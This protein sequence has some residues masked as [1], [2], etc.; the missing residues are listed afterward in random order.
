MGYLKS[1]QHI[2]ITLEASCIFTLDWGSFP[3]FGQLCRRKGLQRKVFFLLTGPWTRKV[4]KI[5]VVFFI[6]SL[7]TA[8]E[9]GHLGHQLEPQI[10][11][12]SHQP[13]KEIITTTVNIKL[14]SFFFTFGSARA[15]S[16]SLRWLSSFVGNSHL[17]QFSFSS[18]VS[19][20]RNHAPQ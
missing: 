7:L 12:T 15:A 2:T 8:Y 3:D 1:R 13:L 19:S 20:L 9:A 4:K 10:W 5:L 14:D 6:V 11:S 18:S 17:T 16:P